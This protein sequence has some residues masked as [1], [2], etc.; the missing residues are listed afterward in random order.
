MQT[1]STSTTSKL[2]DI[3]FTLPRSALIPSHSSAR[4][5][6]CHYEVLVFEP[7]L[8]SPCVENVQRL[9]ASKSEMQTATSAIT[10]IVKALIWLKVAQYLPISA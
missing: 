10:E 8:D 1:Y 6:L 9:N 5:A 4:L 2:A 3:A 7:Y